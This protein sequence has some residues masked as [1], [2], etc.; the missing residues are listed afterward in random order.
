[1]I[2][3]KSFFLITQNLSSK[4]INRKFENNL[5]YHNLK[6]KYYYN[7]IDCEEF[8]LKY[9]NT[10][11]YNELIEI[12]KKINFYLYLQ[13][14]LNISLIISQNALGIGYAFGELL[15][16]SVIPNLLI[17]HGTYYPHKDSDI[18]QQWYFNSKTIINT[19]YKFVLSRSSWMTKY[20]QSLNE[21]KSD[22]VYDGNKN[23]KFSML[24]KEKR[25]II[26]P[27]FYNKVVILHASTP[28]SYENLRPL[29]FENINEYIT[30]L[31]NVIK[32]VSKLTNVHLVVKFRPILNLSADSLS[33]LLIKDPC[34]TIDTD[35]N[36]EDSILNSDFLMS[37][38]STVIEDSLLRKLP[39]LTY[40]PKNKYN[41]FNSPAID[42][43]SI[44]KSSIFFCDSIH[45]LYNSINYMIDNYNIIKENKNLW[46]NIH[47]SDNDNSNFYYNK[48]KLI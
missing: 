13:K 41:H 28:K 39:V 15:R 37:Y 20:I 47:N 31:N 36:I 22:I 38:S 10:K 42:I 5:Y 25:K 14:Q 32:I 7:E 23:Y 9:L 16:N 40:D 30:N 4:Y 35:T 19:K 45:N 34:Y 12:N 1:M 46:D 29:I 26:W 3:K 48:I 11:I 2:K 27:K 18:K 43:N 17:P 8:I 6:H 21:C 24:N 33:N 44:P